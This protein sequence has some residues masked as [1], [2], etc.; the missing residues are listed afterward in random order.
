M[1]SGGVEIYLP[2]SHDLAIFQH[3]NRTSFSLFRVD[4]LF[5]GCPC[6]CP[7]S[8]CSSLCIQISDPLLHPSHVR[9]FDL[10]LIIKAGSLCCLLFACVLTSCKLWTRGGGAVGSRVNKNASVEIIFNLHMLADDQGSPGGPSG[11]WG[12]K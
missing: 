3:C 12:C 7:R 4:F 10:P 6:C 1:A 11:T 2:Q 5:G 8:P 9:A